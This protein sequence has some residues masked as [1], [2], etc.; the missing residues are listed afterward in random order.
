M[1]DPTPAEERRARAIAIKFVGRCGCMHMEVSPLLC[2]R[3]QERNEMTAAISGAIVKTREQRYVMVGWV[4]Q[5]G[6]RQP[7]FTTDPEQVLAWEKQGLVIRAALTEKAARK[8]E[9]AT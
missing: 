6:K 9:E 4:A 2:R 5:R 3:C 7:L 8:G 1:P